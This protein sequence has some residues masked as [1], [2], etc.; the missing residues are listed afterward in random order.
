MSGSITRES[1]LPPNSILREVSYEHLD[2]FLAEGNNA[3]LF[4]SESIR[5]L[6]DQKLEL[7]KK[8]NY[9]GGEGN[10]SRI[11]KRFTKAMRYVVYKRPDLFSS[12]DEANGS[13]NVAN[14][15]MFAIHEYV[16]EFTAALPINGRTK[17]HLMLDL[18]RIANSMRQINA[19]TISNDYL[20]ADQEQWYQRAKQNAADVAV[21][22]QNAVIEP[23]RGGTVYSE[24]DVLDRY[25]AH[26]L[27]Y[28]IAKDSLKTLLSIPQEEIYEE[29]DGDRLTELVSMFSDNLVSAYFI[30]TDDQDAFIA[31]YANLSDDVQL[32]PA[33][34]E[35]AWRKYN[36][37]VKYLGTEGASSVSL[38]AKSASTMVKKMNEHMG[39]APNDYFNRDFEIMHKQYVECVIAYARTVAFVEA[40]YMSNPD[41]L[42][43][44]NKV[45]AKTKIKN[46]IASL[47]QNRTLLGRVWARYPSRRISYVGDDFLEQELDKF[48]KRAKK[49]GGQETEMVFSRSII[50]LVRR[51]K[52]RPSS[53]RRPGRKKK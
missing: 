44:Q 34:Q 22:A 47:T 19:D 20:R 49:W 18:A 21:M 51:P 14:A 40:E 9:L 31:I 26:L 30:S 29:L 45:E 33:K 42:L 3:E 52:D 16:S 24:G 23:S 6:H 15:E 43:S 48:T 46:E 11:I 37:S 53:H 10:P 27:L 8:G 4:L 35:A 1:H 2:T 7:I 17:R 28:N 12:I 41:P 5:L 38:V 36:S 39:L 32:S 50:E 13:T 25:D